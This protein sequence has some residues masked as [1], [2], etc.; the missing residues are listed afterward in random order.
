MPTARLA[1]L[2]PGKGERPQHRTL[3][4]VSFFQTKEGNDMSLFDAMMPN[5]KKFGR[6]HFAEVK[7][8]GEQMN[9]IAE[10]IGPGRT[11]GD[12]QLER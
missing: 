2:E 4:T 10:K 5:G 8:F 1:S 12:F 6:L 11:V 3:A 7:A 9:Q